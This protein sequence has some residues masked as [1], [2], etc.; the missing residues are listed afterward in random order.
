MEAKLA[1]SRGRR[2]GIGEEPIA[3]AEGSSVRVREVR[4]ANVVVDGDGGA[5]SLEMAM[6]S[7]LR[8]HVRS[9][10]I[11]QNKQQGMSFG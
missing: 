6:P 11:D 9:L 5:Y 3:E 4:R 10:M 1:S 7:E 2:S 8:S